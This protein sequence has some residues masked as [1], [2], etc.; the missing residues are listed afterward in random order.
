MSCKI[1]KWNNKQS[2]MDMTYK[3]LTPIMTSL[4]MHLASLGSTQNSYKKWIAQKSHILN[5][6]D[7]KDFYVIKTPQ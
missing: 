3:T 1:L 4:L 7:H 5:K 2:L 6:T